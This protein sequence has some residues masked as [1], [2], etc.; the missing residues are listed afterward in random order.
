MWT[1]L[2]MSARAPHMEHEGQKGVRNLKF[3]RQRGACCHL[4]GG[5][6]CQVN[7]KSF[8]RIF[9]FHIQRRWRQKYH[10]KFGD[11]ARSYPMSHDPHHNMTKPKYFCVRCS[12]LRF[13]M[14][15][16]LCVRGIC[17]TGGNSTN[18]ERQN[19]LCA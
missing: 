3:I 12:F 4:Q 6:V 7:T 2:Q 10:R 17:S 5:V 19:C 8:G 1:C 9:R 13:R 11:L 16:P 15:M 14:K 18:A